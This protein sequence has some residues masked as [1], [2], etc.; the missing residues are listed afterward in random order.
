MR[1]DCTDGSDL[2][3]YSSKES[4]NAWGVARTKQ[5]VEIIGCM[6]LDLKSFSLAL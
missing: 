5:A 1:E 2:I 6:L 4:I 3:K